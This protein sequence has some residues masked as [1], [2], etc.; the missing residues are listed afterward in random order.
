MSE[1]KAPDANRRRNGQYSHGFDRVCVCGGTKGNH[2]AEAPFAC[3][4]STMGPECDGFK[5]AKK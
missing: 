1:R 3:N 4:D 5:L 2:E